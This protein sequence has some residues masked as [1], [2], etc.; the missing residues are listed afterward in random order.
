MILPAK[1][2]SRI[3]TPIEIADRLGVSVSAVATFVVC[4]IAALIGGWWALR[5]PSGVDPEEM[6][7]DVSAV[8]G[9]VAL[10]ESN[11]IQASP[12]F[13]HVVGAV[14]HPGVHE[15]LPGSRVVD[16]IKAAGGL[17]DVA[18]AEHLNLAELL[19]DGVR[20]WVP[21]VGEIDNPAVVLITPEVNSN[22]SSGSQVNINIAGV[23]LLETLPGIG[24]SLAA[25]IVEHRERFGRF[26]EVDDLAGVAG[27]GPA[28]LERL[29]PLVVV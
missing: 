14:V 12:I 17:T 2:K 19:S 16:A 21:E 27:I 26:V 22:G 6:L 18:A 11:S 10:P 8:S 5:P 3:L 23:A 28:K 13:V 29:R 25:A 9:P 7:P 1:S 4:L 20:L 15:L 24:P